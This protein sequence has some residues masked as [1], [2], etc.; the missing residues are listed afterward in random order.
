[1]EFRYTY[2]IYF[3][4]GCIKSIYF[5]SVNF[6]MFKFTDWIVKIT[7][8]YLYFF[9]SVLEDVHAADDDEDEEENMPVPGTPPQKK[10][11]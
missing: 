6:K 1:M 4:Y 7:G 5:N 11:R 8:M 10:V 9:Q 2:T 3:E